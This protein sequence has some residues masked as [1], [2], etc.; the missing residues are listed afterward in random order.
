MRCRAVYPRMEEKRTGMKA[1]YSPPHLRRL[2]SKT[3]PPANE[4]LRP[5][6]Y[7]GYSKMC[8]RPPREPDI[9]TYGLG[10]L[11][12]LFSLFIP[13]SI[14]SVIVT[15]FIILFEIEPQSTIHCWSVGI[16]AFIL[17]AIFLMILESRRSN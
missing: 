11:A 12:I 6:P 13:L 15:P 2:H 9:G 16:T 1:P 8:D 17:T 3:Q 7:F 4:S 5:F 14:A 10:L